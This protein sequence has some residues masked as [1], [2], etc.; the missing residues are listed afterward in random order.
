MRLALSAIVRPNSVRASCRDVR[1]NS[2]APSRSSS[3]LTARDTVA[4]DNPI[5]RAAAANER[6]SATL[7]NI[8]NPSKSG[9]LD[10]DNFATMVFKHF[11]YGNSGVSILSAL[12][13][14]EV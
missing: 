10:I 14:M 9:S 5:T 1:L 13:T 3:R 11:Y 2:R 8:A 12:P 7:A 6:S 4:T